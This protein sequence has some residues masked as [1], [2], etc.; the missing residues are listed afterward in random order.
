[1]GNI[2]RISKSMNQSM[3]FADTHATM[4]G[5]PIF[6]G[7]LNPD[8][9]LVT[10]RGFSKM[11]GELIRRSRVPNMYDIVEASVG[12]GEKLALGDYKWN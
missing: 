10:A 12:V 2:S 7:N 1:M 11:F 9:A 4:N 5:C 8:R 3:A 6:L